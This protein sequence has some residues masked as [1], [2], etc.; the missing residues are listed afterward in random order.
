MAAAKKILK[1]NSNGITN[2]E[3][4]WYASING[5]VDITNFL[6]LKNIVRSFLMT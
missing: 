4:P 5:Y 6:G 1:P 2:Y 3:L